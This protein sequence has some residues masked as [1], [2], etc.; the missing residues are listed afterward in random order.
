MKRSGLTRDIILK[1]SE[2]KRKF[3]EL[4]NTIYNTIKNKIEDIKKILQKY[5]PENNEEFSRIQNLSQNFGTNRNN[6]IFD[7]ELYGYNNPQSLHQA[8]LRGEEGAP[9]HPSITSREM[10]R[11]RSIN[12]SQVSRQ[13][14]INNSQR[15]I[16]APRRRNTTQQNGVTNQIDPE[17]RSSNNIGQVFRGGYRKLKSKKNIRSSKRKSR[18]L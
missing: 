9:S 17:V 14:S 11:Q 18:K 5:N 6:L 13:R 4:K 15:P 10:S 3:K 16:P 12:N 7:P 2:N 1:T 8:R